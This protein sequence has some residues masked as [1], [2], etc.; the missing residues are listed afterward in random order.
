MNAPAP[1]ISIVV[2]A[3]DMA[4]ELP[5]TI[6]SLVQPYQ[7]GLDGIAIELI[8]VDN[9]SRARFD[10]AA[11]AAFDPAIRFLDVE[12]PT[13]SPARAGNIGLAAA[14]GGFAGL[15]I[16]GARIATPGLVRAAWD[17]HRAH[18]DAPVLTL[19]FHLGPDQQQRAMRQGYDQ[20]EEDR[21]LA[22]IDW[23]ARG[24]RLFEI[25]V[26]AGSSKGGWRGPIAESNGLFAPVALWRAIG[27][28]DE[29]F[30]AAGG[31]LVNHD[32]F[33]RMIAAS[34]DDPV[35][36]LG[37]ASFHQIH[38]GASTNSPVS[39]WAEFQAEYASIHGREWRQPE[40][41]S[42]YWGR[43]PGEAE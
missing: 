14:R 1:D 9:G 31:G 42:L 24:E 7:R 5:R 26:L 23:P 19:G 6:R 3:F 18:P 13:Q 32:V 43:G 40:Y 29:R 21:R 41:R 22:S 15:W 2:I 17:A 25:G 30:A 11:C 28:L 27:G 16:D 4:R 37:E 38:G 34:L 33:E 36:L 35:T 20:A 12:A 39:R 10:R 8:V